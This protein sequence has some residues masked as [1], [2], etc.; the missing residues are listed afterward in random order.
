[1]KNPSDFAALM[2]K[3]I[4]FGGANDQ[5]LRVVEGG[6]APEALDL[7]TDLTL[8]VEELSHRLDFS[9]NGV[10]D[11]VSC[12]ELRALAFLS[13]TAAS[14]LQSVRYAVK[15]QKERTL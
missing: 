12:V 9:V 11:P 4:N 15:D 14:L 7:A 5:L 10:G 2:T 13:G 1:M 8:A 6:S 3:R